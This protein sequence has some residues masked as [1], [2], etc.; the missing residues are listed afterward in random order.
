[1]GASEKIY[2]SNFLFTAQKALLNMGEGKISSQ[3]KSPIECEDPKPYFLEFFFGAGEFL[4]TIHNKFGNIYRKLKEFYPE[5]IKFSV[6][7]E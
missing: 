4:H 3:R 6:Y 1:M 7:G 2:G 5:M